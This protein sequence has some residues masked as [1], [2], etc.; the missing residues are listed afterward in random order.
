MTLRAVGFGGDMEVAVSAIA[1]IGLHLVQIR[2][3]LAKPL[4][5]SRCPDE[6][7]SCKVNHG[8]RGVGGVYRPSMDRWSPRWA[9]RSL[10]PDD[11]RKVRRR[12]E[13]AG[14]ER[15]GDRVN[16]PC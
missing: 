10:T 9:R 1:V 6:L 11:A 12:F 2:R 15:L 3:F 14:T 16:R 4:A 13:G 5:Q 7:D 8:A